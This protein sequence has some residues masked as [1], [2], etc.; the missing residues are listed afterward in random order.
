VIKL[1]GVHLKHQ[2]NTAELS[3]E[4]IPAPKYISLP[5]S[6]HIGA[7]A[8]PVVKVGDSVKI[9]Q[10]IGE[11]G[12]GVSSPIYSG[13][14]GTVKKIEETVSS[15]GTKIQ[16]VIIENDGKMEMSD[17]IAPPVINSKDDF[18]DAVRKSGIVGLGGAGFPTYLKFK[19]DISKID[20]LVINGAECEPYITSDTRTMIDDVELFLDGVRLVSDYL[21]VERVFIGI[22]KNKPKCISAVKTL[23][24]DD[25]KISI[26]ALPSIYPQGGEK[27][28]VY[29]TTGRIIKE[30]MLPKDVGVVVI[31]C[32][33]AAAIARYVKTGVPLIEKCITVDGSA[34]KEPKNVIAPIG[35]PISDLFEFCGGFNEE[36]RKVLYGGP[37]MGITVYDMATPVIKQTMRCWLWVKRRQRLLRLLLV[38]SAVDVSHFA[39]SLCPRSKFQERITQ[40][41]LR[42]LKS[43]R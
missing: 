7:P 28:L 1:N 14:S 22:E 13:I 25:K 43:S 37:M 3:A 6:M 23:I 24:A 27:V 10:L 2:K 11:E 41:M 18:L 30:G 42:C 8:K 19:T 16:N 4:R 32:T 20:M 39:H 35:T 26:K 34:V 29:N 31:N 15:N 12:G 21:E 33:T 40:M 36:P 38:Y 9:G 17:D 5:M